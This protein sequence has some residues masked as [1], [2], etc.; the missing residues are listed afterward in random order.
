MSAGA[1]CLSEPTSLKIKFISG[2]AQ[3]GSWSAIVIFEQSEPLQCHVHEQI[4][5]VYQTN[6]VQCDGNFCDEKS[7][8]WMDIEWN[9]LEIRKAL[10]CRSTP[11]VG[12]CVRVGR[13][14]Q[15]LVGPGKAHCIVCRTELCYVDRVAVVFMRH[16]NSE[17]HQQ[18][19]WAESSNYTLPWVEWCLLIH[20]I[21]YWTHLLHLRLFTG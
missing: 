5:M 6:I 1:C 21:I 13:W 10:G 9:H 8:S 3:Y 20:G 7:W 4:N 16:A 19:L 18:K 12:L 11:T 17:A 2:H 14:F 15:K